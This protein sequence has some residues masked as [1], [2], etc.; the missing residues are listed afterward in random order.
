MTRPGVRHLPHSDRPCAVAPLTA[1]F[2]CVGA[3]RL[4][5]SYVGADAFLVISG[6]LLIEAR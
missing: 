6:L 4:G 3:A 2:A 5:G 1:A